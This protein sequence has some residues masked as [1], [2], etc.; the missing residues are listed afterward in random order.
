MFSWQQ[1]ENA[2]SKIEQPL[3]PETSKKA[4]ALKRLEAATKPLRKSIIKHG[5]LHQND[6]DIRLSVATCVSELFRILAPEPPFE[7]N[8]LRVQF[9]ECESVVSLCFYFCALVTFIFFVIY[10]NSFIFRE[11]LNLLSVCLKSLAIPDALSFPR[12]LK[13]WRSLLAL[14]VL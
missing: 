12:E 9:F 3:S 8:Y 4:E 1:V 7:D 6:K 10:V 11:F 5:L 13:Y 14:N 2:L